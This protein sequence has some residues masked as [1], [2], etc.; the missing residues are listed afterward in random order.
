MSQEDIPII[1]IDG[2]SGS[3]KGTVGRLL[4]KEFNWHFLDSGILYRLLALKVM[5]TGIDAN[6]IDSI[7][8]LS[9]NL[10]FEFQEKDGDFLFLDGEIVNDQIREQ[11][12]SAMASQLAVL[13]KVRVSLIELQKVFVLN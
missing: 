6:N 11:E 5:K 7:L 3:G 10:N 4:A 1:T 13:P 8:G 9:N 12:C 2:P